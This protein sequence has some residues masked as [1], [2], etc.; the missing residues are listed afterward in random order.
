VLL[1]TDLLL[2]PIFHGL[3]FLPHKPELPVSLKHAASYSLLYL[4]PSQSLPPLE[5]LLFPYY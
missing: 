1:T 4:V 5:H 3:M 2:Q